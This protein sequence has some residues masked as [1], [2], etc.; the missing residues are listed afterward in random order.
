MPNEIDVIVL[1]GGNAGLTSAISARE[2]GARVLLVEAAPREARG[3]NTYY[4]GGGFKFVH[5][6]TAEACSLIAD[7]SDSEIAAMDMPPYSAD[8]FYSAWMRVTKGLADPEMVETVVSQSMPTM[9]WL[10]GMG[11]CFIPG[12]TFAVRIGDKLK[13]QPGQVVL[14][15][16]DGGMGLSDTLFEI[17]EKKGVEI[18]Y[19]TRGT[20]LLMNAKGY[21]CGLTVKSEAGFEDLACKV[22]RLGV[23]RF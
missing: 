10:T 18:R 17:A 12:M 23:R 21:V 11:V 13:W 7:I 14:D 3:G 2:A 22:G 16:K 19:E 20:R 8:Q 6:G 5:K 15:A 9:K 4:T 1:G